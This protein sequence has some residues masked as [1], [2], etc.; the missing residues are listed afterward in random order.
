MK[1]IKVNKL[2]K[3]LKQLNKNISISPQKASKIEKIKTNNSHSE[4]IKAKNFSNKN[5][6]SL[7][8]TKEKNDHTHKKVVFSP[9]LEKY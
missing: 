5:K 9:N 8:K 1:N 2:S 4:I 3:S 7:N 6:S